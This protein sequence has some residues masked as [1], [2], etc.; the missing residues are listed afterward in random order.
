MVPVRDPDV[1]RFPVIRSLLAPAAL[2]EAVADAYGLVAARC[3][4][5]KATI[6]DVYRVDS[7]Q[8]PSVLAVYQ[9]GR[10]T[11]AEIEAEIDVLDH[12]S[13]HG[14]AVAPALRT[15][16][17]ERLLALPAPEGNRYAVLF[18]FA[19]GTH[20]GRSPDVAVARRCGELVARVHALTD[21]WLATASSA[22]SRAPLDATLLVDRPLALVERLLSRRP[23]DLAEL[24][25]AVGLLRR[26]ISALPQEP[27]RYGLIHGD[28]IPTN[29]LMAPD[30][31]LTLLDFDFCGPGWR[32][33]DVATYLWDAHTRGSPEDAPAAFL[34]GYQ[35]I[36]PLVDW[37]LA[38]VP[39]FA[40]VRG[41][42]RLGNWG[43][44]VEEWG[45]SA[46]T[47]DL[48]EGLMAGI[49]DDLAR[50]S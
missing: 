6:R 24:R 21:D 26:R 42:F 40:A 50:I 37:E 4:L 39:L 11:A 9:H 36:R 23:G 15:R 38:A 2:A 29:I 46:L 7:E 32:V 17:G 41:V 49:R 48:L 16:H 30:G 12:L 19:D 27:P 44:R 28:V 18:R 5:L 8:G 25:R 31:G 47:D 10:R 1:G 13:A 45:T 35:D 34:A 22:R 43:P 33:Y 20:L 14:V 3:Q